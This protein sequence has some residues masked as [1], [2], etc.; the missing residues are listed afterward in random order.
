MSDF[1]NLKPGIAEGI[2]QT[3]L[4][5]RNKAAGIIGMIEGLEPLAADEVVKAQLADAR[6]AAESI[7]TTTTALYR[8]FAKEALTKATP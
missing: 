4:E 3:L 1:P 5:A 7:K 8:R 2:V 6:I